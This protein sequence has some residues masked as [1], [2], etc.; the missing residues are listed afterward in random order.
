MI[1]RRGCPSVFRDSFFEVPLDFMRRNRFRGPTF[2]PTEQPI[3]PLLVI[4][5]RRLV[6]LRVSEGILGNLRE[7]HRG[8]S[9][10]LREL[11]PLERFRLALPIESDSGALRAGLL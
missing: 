10:L 6:S 3:H 7:R 11:P 8:T 9:Q 2:K 5:V 1:D 4:R